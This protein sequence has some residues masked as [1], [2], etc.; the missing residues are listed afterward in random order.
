MFRIEVK[1]KIQHQEVAWD[2]FVAAFLTE[3]LKASFDQIRPQIAAV[4]PIRTTV[5]NVQPGTPQTEP[6]VVN[7]NEAAHLLG[8]KPSTIRAYVSTRRIASVRIGRR[9]LIPMEAINEMIAMG[10][11]PALRKER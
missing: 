11:T 3:S 2:R 8:I 1:F 9:V 10:L 4:P 6:R 5:Q 7:I